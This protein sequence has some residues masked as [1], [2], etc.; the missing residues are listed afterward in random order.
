M[1]LFSND[2]LSSVDGRRFKCLN[3][4]FDLSLQKSTAS[5]LPK[6]SDNKSARNR[7][8]TYLDV[9]FRDEDYDSTFF[10]PSDDAK[11]CAKESTLCEQIDNY[12]TTELKFILSGEAEKFVE[13]F[14][15][16]VLHTVSIA[17]RF[18]DGEDEEPLCASQTRLVYPQAGLTKDNTWRYIVNQS[19][20]TQGVRVEE[21][22]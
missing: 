10:D 12:P 2:V 8:Q 6:F 7:V 5:P 3:I 18:G 9:R 21:C 1:S 20:Y 15:S 4:T 14:R 16:D 13:M 11:K 19:N 22:M 17:N